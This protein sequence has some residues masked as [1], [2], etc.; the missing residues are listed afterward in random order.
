VW[1]TFW[2]TGVLQVKKKFR[3]LRTISF[4]FTLGYSL[5]LLLTTG[6]AALY[7]YFTLSRN[8]SEGVTA[9]LD[10]QLLATAQFISEHSTDLNRIVEEL[11]RRT[12]IDRGVYKLHYGLFNN[13]AMIVAKSKDFPEDVKWT[14]TL[15]G[16]RTEKSKTEFVSH[17]SKMVAMAIY[18]EH[19]LAY[20]LQLGVDLEHIEQILR[21]YR[22]HM[23]IGIPL[24]VFIAMASGFF[25]AK[26]NLSPLTKI[27][28]TARDITISNLDQKLPLR[29]SGDELDELAETFNDMFARLKASYQKIIQFTAD[30]SHELRLPITAIKGEAEVV[31]ERERDVEEYRNVLASIIEEFDRLTKMVN[32]LLLLS[33]SDSGQDVLELKDVQLEEILTQLHDFFKVAALNKE[34]Q[35]E[36]GDLA[37]VRIK[38][39][40]AKLEQLFSNL[41]DNALKYTHP[42]GYIEL[43]LEDQFPWAK[44]K[45]RDTGCGIPGDEIPKIFERF[46]RV[47]RSRSRE[48]GGSGLGLSICRY[49]AEAHKGR[50]E[51]E[52]QVGKGTTFTVLLP[53]QI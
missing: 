47:D 4:K 34:I 23:F 46:Y 12:L 48:L 41:I 24:V 49:I 11:N 17:G 6:F 40:K 52:S 43:S 53:L 31:L 13:E 14:Q 51:V 29:G 45:I 9:Y 30:A 22:K 20:F 33:R 50:I 38:G 37:S 35:F 26:R 5:V 27:T 44:V 19:G 21:N 15:K 18:D 28:H 32:S 16:Q 42:K 7:F 3:F 25:L 1:A 8:L 10:N 2:K 36:L 39:D